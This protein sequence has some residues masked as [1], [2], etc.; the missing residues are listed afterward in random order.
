MLKQFFCSDALEP[1]R[2][3]YAFA[4]NTTLFDCM[5]TSTSIQDVDLLNDFC[6]TATGSTLAPDPAKNLFRF[7]ASASLDPYIATPT[8]SLAVQSSAGSVSSSSTTR[9]PTHTGQPQGAIDGTAAGAAVI[10][11]LMIGVVAIFCVRA[12]RRKRIAA[13]SSPPAYIQP[14]MGQQAQQ[15]PP[16]AFDGYHS[17]PQQ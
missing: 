12:R 7:T 11:V 9:G 15:P 3:T 8:N 10:G 5:A 2:G 4:G 6:I 16:R 14:P 1:F 17:V 13:A